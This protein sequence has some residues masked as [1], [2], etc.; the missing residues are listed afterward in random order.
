[1]EHLLRQILYISILFRNFSPKEHTHLIRIESTI[2]H[3]HDFLCDITATAIV[4]DI[5][6]MMPFIA[7]RIESLSSSQLNT[8]ERT[9]VDIALHLQNPGDESLV[10]GN[11]RH[12]PSWHIMAFAHRVELD[13][14]VFCSRHLHNTHRMLIQHKRIR[15]VIHHHDIMLLGKFH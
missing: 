11:H 15:I 5:I 12:T 3:L 8:T 4:H 2:H 6:L 13:T 14:A 9:V 7:I 10:A 1:M